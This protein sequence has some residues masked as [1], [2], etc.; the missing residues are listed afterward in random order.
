[1]KQSLNLK[2]SQQ[3]TMTPQLQQAIKLLQLSHLEL[4]TNP[5]LEMVDENQE[6]DEEF[7]QLKDEESSHIQSLIEDFTQKGNNEPNSDTESLDSVDFDQPQS[8]LEDT[9]I[10]TVWDDSAPITSTLSARDTDDEI[11][12][13]ERNAPAATLYD[14]LIW[15]LNLTRLSPMDKAIGLAII[16]ALDSRGYFVTTCEE[17]AQTVNREENKERKQTGEEELQGEDLIQPDEVHA[18]LSLIQQLDPPGVAAENLQ[19]CLLLQLKQF[20]PET[21][22]RDEAIMLISDHLKLI[23]NRDFPNLIKKTKLSEEQ[24]KKTMRLIKTLK[25]F[26][27]QTIESSNSEYI[28]PDII[29]KKD[30]EG[31]KVELNADIAA[32]I[33]VNPN[34]AELSRHATKEG[35]STFLKNQMQEAKWFIKSL[36]SRNETLLKVSTKIV[37]YQRAFFEYGV[38]AMKPLILHDIADAVGMHESTISRVTTQKFMHT[39]YGIF[40]LKYFFSSHVNTTSGGECSSTAIRAMIKKLIQAENPKKPLSDST[41]SDLLKKQ[42]IEVARRTVAKY[43]EAM[44]IPPSNERKRL[45]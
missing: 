16:E 3:L 33:R 26:P 25:P 42:N 32:R 23:E 12:F 20:P 10:D 34:Y 27:A 15:Q 30:K 2:M 1:M 24:L 17:I 4:E 9:N 29:V 22:F 40:E 37:E 8:L 18:V 45:V 7:A 36:Q 19:Q 28:V 39:P 6:R 13:D 44:H 38:E 41:L 14:H 43:R 21:L 5:L 31:W 11:N 35:D